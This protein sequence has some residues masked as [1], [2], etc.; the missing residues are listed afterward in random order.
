MISYFITFSLYLVIDTTLFSS[1]LIISVCFRNVFSSTFQISNDSHR[2]FDQWFRNRSHNINKITFDDVIKFFETRM[3]K[4]ST[5]FLNDDIKNKFYVNLKFWRDLI[6]IF[7]RYIDDVF[8]KL[9]L[10]LNQ[11]IF[12]KDIDFF[13]VNSWISDDFFHNRSWSQ[14]SLIIVDV[15]KFFEVKLSEKWTISLNNDTNDKVYLNVKMFDDLISL[16]SNRIN[17]IFIIIRFIIVDFEFFEDWKLSKI[18]QIKQIQ[19]KYLKI[20][21]IRCQ[22]TE[23]V[24]KTTRQIAQKST[25]QTRK[26]IN[27]QIS[28]SNI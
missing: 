27:K 10:K 14:L 21:M 1:F 17:E 23:N 26:H 20:S 5:I 25:R 19:L 15:L 7:R 2:M 9:I 28:N 3:K 24:I 18:V 13:F 12:R 4:K 16:F 22:T 6:S 11:K 8:A